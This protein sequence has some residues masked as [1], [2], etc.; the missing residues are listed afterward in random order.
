MNIDSLPLTAFA[1]EASGAAA[2][3]MGSPHTLTLKTA[4]AFTGAI[5]SIV[6]RPPADT[7]VAAVPVQASTALVLTF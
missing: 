1:L 3:A 5:V 2:Q 7:S 6:V 4:A